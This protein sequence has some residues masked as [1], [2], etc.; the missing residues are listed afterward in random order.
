ML[1]ALARRNER[2]L[3]RPGSPTWYGE[4]GPLSRISEQKREIE[5]LHE[6]IAALSTA[7]LRVSSSLDL[8]TVLRAAAEIARALTGARYAAITTLNG[9]GRLGGSWNGRTTEGRPSIA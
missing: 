8:G 6:R 9:S 1:T 7:V 5:A 3:H 2:R 4:E